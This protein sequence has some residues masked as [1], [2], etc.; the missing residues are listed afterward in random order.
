[1]AGAVVVLIASVVAGTVL[2]ELSHALL[3]S[4]LGV[5][6]DVQLFRAAE[7][8]EDGRLSGTLVPVVPDR[9]TGSATSFRVAALMALTLAFPFVLVPAGVVPHSFT[10]GNP[11]IQLAVAGWLACAIPSPQDFSVAWYARREPAAGS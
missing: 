9:T 1:L 4:V 5:P 6:S 8:G 7:S 11:A 10:T 2:H 3:L